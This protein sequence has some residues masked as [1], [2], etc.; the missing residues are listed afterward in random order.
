LSRPQVS[1]AAVEDTNTGRV[2][3]GEGWFV[4]NLADARWERDPDNGAWCAF[5]APD[6]PFSQYAVNVHVLM[7]GQANGRYHA[8]SNQEGFLVLHGECIAIVEGDEHP[9]RQWDFLHCPPGTHHIF[10]GAG[11]GPCAILMTGTRDPDYWLHYPVDEVA[12]RYG[13]SVSRPT[14]SSKEAYADL[15]H[16]ATPERAPAPFAPPPLR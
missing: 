3:K 2:V 5:E 1:E 11:D 6:A 16:T 13:A 15:V 14:D 12:G 4:L 7:P 10:V 9:M 8:E